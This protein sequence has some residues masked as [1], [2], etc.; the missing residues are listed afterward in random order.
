MSYSSAEVYRRPRAAL[1]HSGKKERFRLLV[2]FS[3][4]AGR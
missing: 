4:S 1:L 3:R 2:V